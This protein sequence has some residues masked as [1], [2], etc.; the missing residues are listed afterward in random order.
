MNSSG[1]RK[2]L[3]IQTAFIGDVILA[4]SVIENLAK[5]EEEFQL[6]FMLRKG[7]ESLLENH[8]FIHKI[9][10]WDKKNSK[11]KNLYKILKEVRKQGY[12]FVINLQRFAS[13]GLFTVFSN[14][15]KKIGFDKNPFS[16]FFDVRVRHEISLK[17]KMHEIDRN[18]LLLTNAGFLAKER[19]VKLYSSETDKALVDDYRT[20]R[21]LVFAPASVWF[22]KQY[23]LEKWVQ[24][25]NLIPNSYR[26]IFSGANSDYDL[27]Q[28]II[29]LS[30]HSNFL[31]LCGKL[32]FLQ[33][34][35]LMKNSVRCFVNDSAP[36]HLASAANAPT[37][38]IFCSTVPEF[39]FGPLSVNS[40]I[41]QNTDV[42]NC[43]PC[44]L[45]GKKECPEKHFKCA[46]NIK[47]SELLKTIEDFGNGS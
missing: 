46:F 20:S 30:T 31:N 15:D 23:P 9:Y 6:D 16:L 2:I 17:G 40:K 18:L 35:E 3:I 29:S 10:C 5:Q 37:T 26:I 8:P 33:S 27:S 41:V 13:S 32:S 1:K 11:I 4:T 43:R 38:A 44:G 19:C 24:L 42:L 7:N 25:S 39:G 12:D 47:E 28:K 45:H 36:L 21:Y 34:M 22:T 14:A